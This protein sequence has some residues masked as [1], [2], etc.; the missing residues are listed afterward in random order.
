V[1]D[2]QD[3]LKFVSTV[4]DSEAGRSQSLGKK[5]VSAVLA[6]HDDGAC[7]VSN[8]MFTGRANQHTE[9]FSVTATTHDEKICPTRF[10]DEYRCGVTFDDFPLHHNP[11]MSDPQGREYWL[12]HFLSISRGIVTLRNRDPPEAGRPLPS[13]DNLK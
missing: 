13:R 8:A 7:R 1:P 2:E 4:T 11:R 12:E 10:L 5:K 3:S 6:K 9:K